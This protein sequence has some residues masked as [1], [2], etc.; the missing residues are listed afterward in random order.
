MTVEQ[1]EAQQHLASLQ[2]SVEGGIQETQ[3]YLEN[4]KKQLM[5]YDAEYKVSETATGY[6]QTA[7]ESANHAVDE[8]KKSAE[9]LRSTTLSA[10]QKPVS[11]VQTAL[12]QVT[13]SL[14][15]IKD[16]AAVYDAKFKNAVGEAKTGVEN[17]TLAT[18]QRTT[19]AIHTASEHAHELQVQLSAKAA[20]VSQ[21]AIAYAGGVVQTVE[22]YDQYYNLSAT[23]HEKV[24]LATEKAKELDDQYQVTQKAFDV[25]AKVT[26]GLG[27]RAIQKGTDMVSSSVAYLQEKIQ[28]AKDVHNN[29]ENASPASPVASE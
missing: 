16:Q 9:T 21:S 3:T 26:G 13:D 24:Q 10:A 20:G 14:A 19:D 7:I 4:L 11:L 23:L 12:V 17:L 5:A 29:S 6:L 22:A 27:A 2:T 15:T 1:P 28:Y 18:R 8:L 25:D